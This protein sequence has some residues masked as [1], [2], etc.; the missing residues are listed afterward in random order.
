[1]ISGNKPSSIIFH[2]VI[3][4]LVFAILI[5]PFSMQAF[6]ILY[7]GTEA[8]V[9]IILHHAETNQLDAINT[10]MTDMPS[11][12]AVVAERVGNSGYMTQQE[13]L[14]LQSQGHE[15]SSH[16]E[17]HDIIDSSTS[18]EKLYY[19][20][21]QSKIDLEN[22]GLDVYGF[23]APRNIMTDESFVL[24][25]QNYEW[26]EFFSPITYRP[27]YV[28]P[29]VL[30][31]SKDTYGLYHL[32]AW[33]VGNGDTLNN[34]QDVK[35]QIDYAIANKYWIAFNFHH[36]VDGSGTY[37]ISPA[38]FHEII[39]YVR[40]QRDAGNLDVITMAEGVGLSNP[41]LI[42]PTTTASPSGG[43]YS[44]SQLVTLTANEVATIYYTTDGSPPTTSSPVYSGPILISSDI[45][46]QFFAVDTDG[47]EESVKTEVYTIVDL[48]TAPIT[49][50]N[51]NNTI[52]SSNPCSLPITIA[53]GSDR[54]II[55]VST[56][57]GKF[58]PIN[59][60]DISG[61]TGQ[62]ILVGT[63]Q[64]GSGSTEQNVE[65]WRIM[66]SDISNGANTIT[67]HFTSTP[68]DAG[69]SL[70][71]FSG[72]AQ[73]PEESK[74]S[75]VVTSNSQISTQIT[76]LTDGSLIVS[77]VGHGQTNALYSSHGP[78]QI[79]R[80]N[81]VIPSAGHGVTTEIKFSAGSDVQSHTLS[82]SANR[83]A[84]FVAS[85]A[86]AS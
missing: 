5:M 26:T 47:N 40:A 30:D 33:G 79:E 58:N 25:Q 1:M 50:D 45:T 38:I 61:G 77:A 6:A 3:I 71:S 64:I 69:V 23:I 60:I 82:S 56:E 19:E 70:V 86:P 81:F 14:D 78:D 18:P 85:F 15:I 43:T 80:H 22:M 59:S 55:V 28:S 44:S 63:K 42:P 34:F 7:D 24:I 37:D 4:F 62:G 20:T 57:E 66:E 32:P 83:Q 11:I 76:T 29:E 74:A 21:V 65:M 53:S 39:D 36:I 73:Q 51:S 54:M 17:S 52:C 9:S 12:I 10:E 84:Q 46:L 13:L 48:P 31:Y 16:S 75:N 68:S 72:V 49:F 2:S 8:A 67:V 41:S 27:K 35:T